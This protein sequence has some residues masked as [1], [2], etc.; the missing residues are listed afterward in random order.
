MTDCHCEE[1]RDEA[2]SG[3]VRTII[4]IASTLRASQ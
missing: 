2:I 3:R 4:E 1:W